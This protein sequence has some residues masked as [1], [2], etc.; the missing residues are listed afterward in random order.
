MREQREQ[1]QGE[2]KDLI[3]IFSA[4]LTVIEIGSIDIV[5]HNGTTSSP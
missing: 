4:A 2:K 1:Q 5:E 3:H